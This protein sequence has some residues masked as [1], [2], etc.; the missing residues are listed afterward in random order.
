MM[1]QIS[2]KICLESQKTFPDQSHTIWE[3]LE[4][5][6]ENRILP[7]HKLIFAS[8]ISSLQLLWEPFEPWE[9]EKFIF[10]K[11]KNDMKNLAREVLDNDPK[12]LRLQ[13]LDFIA[14]FGGKVSFWIRR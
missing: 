1:I 6:E 7:P 12:L 8:N 5:F 10:S 11:N 13:G 2:W 3:Y 9:W 14:Q 4:A